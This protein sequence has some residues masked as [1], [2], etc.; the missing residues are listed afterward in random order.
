MKI[1]YAAGALVLTLMAGCGGDDGCEPYVAQ[2]A[3]ITINDGITGLPIACGS[4]VTIGQW[5][6]PYLDSESCDDSSA[7]TPHLGSGTFELH[8]T[9]P[10]YTDWSM[11]I[12]AVALNQCG[13]ITEPAVVEAFLNPLP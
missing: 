8:I 3:S 1:R 12:D 9:K 13:T 6:A 11:T 5:T 10:G 4:S 2:T 7:I